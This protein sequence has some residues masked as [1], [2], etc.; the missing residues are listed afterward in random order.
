MVMK[1]YYLKYWRHLSV[2]II[3]IYYTA[4]VVTEPR[5]KCPLHYNGS[6]P[7]F[8]AAQIHVAYTIFSNAWGTWSIK[9]LWYDQV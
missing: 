7:T 8:G 3:F 9:S 6:T 1:V 2:R 4:F 5:K